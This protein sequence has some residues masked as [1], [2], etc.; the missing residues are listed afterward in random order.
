ML[1][2]ANC[3]VYACME[4]DKNGGNLPGNCPMRDSEY[5]NNIMEAYKDPEI[6]RFYIVTKTARIPG[7]APNFTPRLIGVINMMKKMGYKKI[8]L[9]FCVGF[10]DEADLY[11]KIL[12]KHGFEVVSVSCCN[13]GFNIADHGVPLPKG[14]DFDA[15]CN[16]LGQAKLMNRENVEFNLV[17]GLCAG[18]DSLFMAH[19]DAM[20]TVIAVKDPATGHTP[21]MALY[22]YNNYYESCFEPKPLP[23]EQAE[24]N[25]KEE[26]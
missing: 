14:C 8:G 2:C 17:M 5:M 6:K 1:S 10:K 23:W 24:D 26:K 11:S 4:K 19:A 15:A 12:R 21:T 9:A 18:H 16:P 7:T 3:R 13:C 20:S 25:V 22:L